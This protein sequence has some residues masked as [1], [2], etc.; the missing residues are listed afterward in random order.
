ME[1]RVENTSAVRRKVSITIPADRVGRAWQ[2]VLRKVGGQA[3]IPGFRP[4]KAPI[5]LLERRFAT[6]IREE[7]LEAVLGPAVA[8]AIESQPFEAIGQPEL[9]EVS[10]VRGD[11]ALNATFSVDV[12]PDLTV[13]LPKG[14]VIRIDRVVPDEEDLNLALQELRNKH[15]EQRDIDGPAEDGD[16]LMV[17]YV[18]KPQVALTPEVRDLET[19]HVHLGSAGEDG[20]LQDLVR[21]KRAHDAVLGEVEL[22][23]EAEHELAG[24]PCQI[25]GRVLWIKRRH[26]PEIGDELATA[27]GDADLAALKARLQADLEATATRRQQN[28]RQKAALN[29]LLDHHPVQVPDTLIESE[30]DRRLSRVFGGMDLSR[31]PQLR[32]QLQGLRGELKPSA[33]RGVAEGLMMR[34]LSKTDGPEISE[35]A[36]DARIEKLA[37]D[38]PEYADRVRENYQAAEARESLQMQ[39]AEEQI[40]E[41]VLAA[42]TLEEGRTLTLRD[43]D[44]LPETP[45]ESATEGQDA[46]PAGAQDAEEAAAAEPASADEAAEPEA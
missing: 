22:P 44:E 7:V 2:K 23:A 26:V 45:A 24:R 21:G 38:M 17:E 42:A 36:V 12:L 35:E 30:I 46:A 10:E 14:D 34:H 6:V 31:N 39:L 4:G 5:R 19:T 37:A 3:R 29:W 41:G 18:L 43:P 9:H 16:D 40:L 11:L 20:W 25:E 32:A 15:A 27:A 1:I 28:L 33:A 13:E 8:E